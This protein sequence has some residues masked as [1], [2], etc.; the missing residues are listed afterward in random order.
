VEEF[1]A[2]NDAFVREEPALLFDESSVRTAVTY[3]GG[4]WLRRIR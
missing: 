2:E 4:G 3:F 1:L